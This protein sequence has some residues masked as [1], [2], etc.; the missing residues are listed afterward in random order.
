MLKVRLPTAQLPSRVTV[1]VRL[2]ITLPK[3]TVSG[4]LPPGTLFPFQLPGRFQ[5]PPPEF[6]HASVEVGSVIAKT[7]PSPLPP[8]N[9][10]FPP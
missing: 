2:P 7:V 3:A 9:D 5:L 10:K 4:V 8:F 6:A 1:A